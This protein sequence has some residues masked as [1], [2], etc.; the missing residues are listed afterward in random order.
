MAVFWQSPHAADRALSQLIF[1]LYLGWN[2][3]TKHL[4]IWLNFFIAPFA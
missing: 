1:K 2:S 3:I 4:L